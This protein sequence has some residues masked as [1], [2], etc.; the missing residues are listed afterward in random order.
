MINRLLN[1]LRQGI[2]RRPSSEFAVDIVQQT[3]VAGLDYE[4]RRHV[5]PELRL[6]DVL[7]LVREPQN[8]SDC[9]AIRV[10]TLKGQSV[11]FVNKPAAEVLAPHFDSG[12]KF[13]AFVTGIEGGRYAGKPLLRIGIVSEEGAQPKLPSDEY[14]LAYFA[15]TR[16]D[17]IG[18]LLDGSDSAR[19]N[20]INELLKQGFKCVNFRKS[21]RLA[22]DGH[23]YDWSLDVQS[24]TS[25]DNSGVEVIQDIFAQ[26]WHLHRKEDWDRLLFLD[27]ELE[28]TREL[29]TKLKAEVSDTEKLAHDYSEDAGREQQERQKADMKLQ[30]A[31]RRLLDLEGEKQKWAQMRERVVKCDERM[32]LVIQT[33]FPSVIFLKNSLRWALD[34][35]NDPIPLMKVLNSIS[36]VEGDQLRAKSVKTTKDWKE[37]HFNT[38]YDDQGRIYFRRA[39]DGLIILISDKGRQNND[40]EF[41]RDH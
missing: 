31:E 40:F 20:V 37:L 27:E 8:S 1:R 7:R 14:P 4:E 13:H 21:T 22:S 17:K 30:D 41:L 11:G 15:E 29:I 33:L 19:Q 36:G 28:K 35:V 6:E 16:G 38:G 26:C 2:F 23:Q 18:L 25:G 24:S 9:N 10:E 39:G 12:L 3:F 32:A 5:L 34:K